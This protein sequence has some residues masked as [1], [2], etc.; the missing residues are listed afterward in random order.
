MAE[1]ICSD[2]CFNETVRPPLK[3]K[4][5]QL[6]NRGGAFAGLAE[7]EEVVEAQEV[8]GSTVHQIYIEYGVDVPGNLPV[9]RTAALLFL[10]VFKQVAVGA[11]QGRE[12]GI[13]INRDFL[14]V[15]DR[16]RPLHIA[17]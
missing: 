8:L 10:P 16:N 13:E 3:P 2:A 11:L 6:A 7:G 5:A 1:G 4:F 12:A 9:Q 17:L 15:T 14:A